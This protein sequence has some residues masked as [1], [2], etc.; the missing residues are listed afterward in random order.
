M[1]DPAALAVKEPEAPRSAKV[2]VVLKD[3]RTLSHF[4]HHAYG[5]KQNP[6]ETE[7]VNAKTRILMEPVVGTSRTEEVIQQVHGLEDVANILELMPF[8]TGDSQ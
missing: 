4:T 1:A 8:L 6:I 3:G 7:S 2:E 5:T